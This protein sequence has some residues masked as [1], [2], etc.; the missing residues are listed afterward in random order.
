MGGAPLRPRGA[1]PGFTMIELMVVVIIVGILAAIATPIYARYVFNSRLTE[2]TGHMADIV[3]AAKAFAV[4]NDADGNPATVDWPA[5][6]AAAGFLGDCASTTNLAR[7]GVEPS[8]SVLRITTIGRAKMDG[9]IVTMTVDGLA[10]NG[11]IT[12][13][14]LGGN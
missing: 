12:V 2:A 5:S 14:R 3:T 11:I 10:A 7:Y 1:R 6:C 9:Y 13:Q 4:A 8:G